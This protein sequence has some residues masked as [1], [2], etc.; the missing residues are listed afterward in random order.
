MV[1]L[2]TNGHLSRCAVGG[3]TAKMG[4]FCSLIRIHYHP[5][6]S[7]AVSA[8]SQSLSR[9]WPGLARGMAS[10]SLPVQLCSGWIDRQ[11][12]GFCSTLNTPLP[13]YK[14][15]SSLPS[16]LD[17][18]LAMMWELRRAGVRSAHAGDGPIV[19]TDLCLLVVVSPRTARQSSQSTLDPALPMSQSQSSPSR[20]NRHQAP[21]DNAKHVQRGV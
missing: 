8:E 4:G 20:G 21:N 5:T 15:K 18:L 3:V 2:G 13:S 17:S 6:S 1:R 9:R 7:R 14:L 12:S 10:H 19:L 16:S 11:G